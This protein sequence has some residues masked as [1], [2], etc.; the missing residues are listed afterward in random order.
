MPQV[1]KKAERQERAERPERHTP[2]RSAAPR[3]A[4]KS[5]D[6]WFDRPYEPD[7]GSPEVARHTPRPLSKQ[8]REIPALLGGLR[9]E[10]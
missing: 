2:S 9:L 5:S 7:A 6:A 4:A 10:E 3:I 8:K 1:Q